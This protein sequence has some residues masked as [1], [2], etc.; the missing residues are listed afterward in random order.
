MSKSLADLEMALASYAHL[1]R[2]LEGYGRLRIGELDAARVASGICDLVADDLA[3][4]LQ[5]ESFVAYS[6]DYPH[7]GRSYPL[8]LQELVAFVEDDDGLFDLYGPSVLNW[9][10]HVDPSKSPIHQLTMIE[11]EDV[12]L[13]VDFTAHQY[14]ELDVAHAFPLIQALDWASRWHPVESLDQIQD[15]PQAPAIEAR[16]A[17]RAKVYALQQL[18]S[19]PA[20]GSGLT[21]TVAPGGEA[22]LVGDASMLDKEYVPITV[23]LAAGAQLPDFVQA[24]HEQLPEFFAQTARPKLAGRPLAHQTGV[25]PVDQL[26]RDFLAESVYVSGSDQYQPVTSWR[27]CTSDSGYCHGVSEALVELATER[28]ICA[29]ISDDE[30][31]LEHLDIPEALIEHASQLG[32]PY[33]G[34]GAHIVAV[35]KHDDRVFVADYTASQF[36]VSEFPVVRELIDGGWQIPRSRAQS[37]PDIE[38]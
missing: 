23:Q 12:V 28:G 33:V 34:I 25:A 36:G 7:M 9:Y 21:V 38:R 11:I 13:S 29:A 22:I 14:K 26:L 3:Q 18:E 10:P 5:A 1:T 19:V 15:L 6:P 24:V 35:I 16:F 2:E 32:Y 20:V 27:E 8:Q 30:A 37:A 4:Y 31:A 17:G